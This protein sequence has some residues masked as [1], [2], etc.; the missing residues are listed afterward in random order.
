M[1]KIDEIIRILKE[2]KL[3]DGR[4]K[5]TGHYDEKIRKAVS[6]YQEKLKNESHYNKNCDGNWGT[7]TEIAHNKSL[8]ESD[9]EEVKKDEEK[10]KSEED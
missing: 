2:N 9:K 10:E 1:K 4:T 8:K 5:L 3:I 7:Y 6:K